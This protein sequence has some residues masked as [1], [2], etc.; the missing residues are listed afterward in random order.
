MNQLPSPAIL[1]RLVYKYSYI[2]NHRL[3]FNTRKPFHFHSAILADT[4]H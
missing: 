3:Y 4:L 2:E 1:L